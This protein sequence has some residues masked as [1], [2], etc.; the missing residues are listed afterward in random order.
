MKGPPCVGLCRETH[1]M[2]SRSYKYCSLQNKYDFHRSS[3]RIIFRSIS[4]VLMSIWLKRVLIAYLPSLILSNVA[5]NIAAYRKHEK[6]SPLTLSFVLT[7]S[8]VSASHILHS[9]VSSSTD[10]REPSDVCTFIIAWAQ[11][12]ISNT[13]SSINCQEAQEVFFLRKMSMFCKWLS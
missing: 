10:V 12:L 3:N 13:I 8:H 7:S 9:R 5:K 2:C 4:T 6:R 11:I 1:Q